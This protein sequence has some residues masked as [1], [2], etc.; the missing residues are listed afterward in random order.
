MTIPLLEASGPHADHAD[1]MMLYGRFVGS[2]AVEAEQLDE[3]GAWTR[4]HGEWHFGWGLG[5]LAVI[6]VI[7][8]PPRPAVAEGRPFEDIG[9]TVRV[10]D[11]A[12]DTWQITFVSAYYRRVARLTGRGVGDEV[13]QDGH[14]HLGQPIRWNFTDIS[15]DSL[16]WQGY[17]S[18]DGG[19]S[20]RLTEQMH[21]RRI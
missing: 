8:A 15:A 16:T 7:H 21:L 6:D 4:S 2:W 12:S 18:P 10:Y 17:D 13:H 20:W 11:P 1:A 9:T 5:G 3:A 19:T 14:D